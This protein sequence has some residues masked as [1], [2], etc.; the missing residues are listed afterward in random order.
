MLIAL[1]IVAMLM[2]AT[3]VAIDASFQAYASAAGSAST[4]TTARLTVYRLLRL[5]RTSTAHG[6]LEPAPSG[7]GSSYWPDGWPTSM[8][9]ALKSELE[10][11]RPNVTFPAPAPRVE[12][13]KAGPRVKSDH[14]YIIDPQGNHR[15][16]TYVQVQ[17]AE[18]RDNQPDLPAVGELWLT[19]LPRGATEP[20]ARPLLRGVTREAAA[21]TLHRRL[22]RTGAWVLQR[23]SAHFD[24]RPNDQSTLGIER[25]G[26]NRALAPIQIV[27]STEPRRME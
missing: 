3:M 1:T 5:I 2:A 22:D 15:L 18:Q 14:L 25:D 27:A 26:E 23:G 9:T 13:A 11:A 12:P 17:A 24:V 21:F 10:A 8:K 6:P 4:Q 19:T 20:T 7:S 16:I